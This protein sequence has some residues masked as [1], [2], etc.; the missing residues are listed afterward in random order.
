MARRRD[1]M[2]AMFGAILFLATSSALTV[3]VIVTIIQQHKSSSPGGSSTQNSATAASKTNSTDI[4]GTKLQGFTPLTTP[5]TKL[6]YV[7]TTVGTGATVQAGATITADYTGA[8]ADSGVIFDASVDHGGPQTFSLN[9]VIAGWAQG[10]PGMK[11]G[12]TRELLIP[13]SLAYGSSAQTGI[14][15]N[16]DLVFNVTITK[17]D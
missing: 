12:G 10:I 15:A 5:L 2:F 9:S 11:V 17:I 1:R 6:E 13:A 7:D 16:S 8:L 14:P 3:V 4:A